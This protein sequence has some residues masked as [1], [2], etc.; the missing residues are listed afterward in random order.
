VNQFILKLFNL[1]LVNYKISIPAFIIGILLFIGIIP[2]TIYLHIMNKRRYGVLNPALP[3]IHLKIFFAI[4]CLVISNLAS[5]LSLLQN[6][7]LN[8]STGMY[9]KPG[10]AFIFV[11]AVITCTIAG[12]LQ[13]LLRNDFK[14]VFGTDVDQQRSSRFTRIA[15][16]WTIVSAVLAIVSV[17]TIVIM[18][19]V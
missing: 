15:L 18:S 10:V 13:L 11:T 5:V 19:F 14:K 8:T 7:F 3:Q 6:F 1:S 4:E 17:A 12:G 9:V 2:F 16:I